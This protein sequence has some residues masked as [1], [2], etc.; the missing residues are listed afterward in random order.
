MGPE[1]EARVSVGRA[2]GVAHLTAAGLAIVGA[3]LQL[4]GRAAQTPGTLRPDVAVRLV[5]PAVGPLPIETWFRRREGDSIV[6]RTQPMLP[7][8]TLA[9]ADIA[10]VEVAAGTRSRWREGAG[11]GFGLGVGAGALTG[12]FAEV[13]SRAELTCQRECGA[14]TVVRAGWGALIGAA[15]GLAVG[16]AIGSGK[17]VTIWR[18][19]E[20]G[21][22]GAVPAG[23]GRTPPL[24]VSFRLTLGNLR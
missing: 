10:S 8:L 17:T 23:K 20:L 19:F 13:F 3:A 9:I 21:S 16:A 7:E 24:A 11:R 15:A 14:T 5:V 1:S 18:P 22:V 2:A 4:P 12:V 6:V